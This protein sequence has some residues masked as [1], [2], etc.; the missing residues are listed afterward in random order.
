M[1]SEP[2]TNDKRKPT[3]HSG[4]DFGRRKVAIEPHLCVL[5]FTR[6]FL[7]NNH[8]FLSIYFQDNLSMKNVKFGETN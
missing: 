8:D 5:L 2:E 7:S 1:S 6:I 3:V 4:I